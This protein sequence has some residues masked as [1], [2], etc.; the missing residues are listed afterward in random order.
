MSLILT[1]ILF[2]IGIII[3]Y[4]A[5]LSLDP[6]IISIGMLFIAVAILNTAVQII[7]FP[8]KPKRVELRVVET[9]ETPIKPKRRKKSKKKS[10]KRRKR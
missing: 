6:T 4:F 2:I 7:L 8:T 5:T 10:K 3:V 1:P 9:K